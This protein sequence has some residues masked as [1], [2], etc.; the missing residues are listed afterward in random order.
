MILAITAEGKSIKS[1]AGQQKQIWGMV[2]NEELD[3]VLTGFFDK[4]PIGLEQ[5]EMN[6]FMRECQTVIIAIT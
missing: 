4:Y 3:L 1:V 2:V 5:E 6:I